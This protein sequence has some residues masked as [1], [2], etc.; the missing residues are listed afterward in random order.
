MVRR[1][2]APGKG[3]RWRPSDYPC[4]RS[5]DPAPEVGPGPA[6]T[7]RWPRASGSAWARSAPPC[8][9]AQAAG[10]DWAQVQAPDRRGPGGAA[11]RAARRRRSRGT[12]P[13]P[14]CAYLHAERR[15]PGVTLE[16]LHLEYLEQHPDGYRY[17]QFCELYRRWLR[18]R[19]LSMRQVHRAGEKLLRRLRRA[20]SRRSSTPPTGRG[21]RGRALRRRPRRL[22][23]HLR[24][25]D[26]HPAGPR[27]DRQPPAGLRLLRRRH[28]RPSSA[29]SSRAA[30]PSPA[31]TSRACSAPTRS[32]RSTTAP[33]SCP[34]AP[35]PRDKRQAS[36]C[37]SF[38]H[39]RRTLGIA[40]AIAEALPGMG[41][42]QRAGR[43]A[44]RGCGPCHR[45]A[46][47]A[48]DA[49]RT[50]SAW[51]WCDGRRVGRRSRVAVS[52]PARAE[53]L[54][55]ARDPVGLRGACGP[56]GG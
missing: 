45:R 14:D 21:H 54:G 15:K 19:G 8:W 4:D 27:L 41:A 32:S 55:Q 44:R 40:A 50:R 13:S 34:P 18:R 29:I 46:R 47:R 43:A 22:E 1:P 56:A 36:Y 11:V 10:L 24:R 33:S 39:V 52:H 5:G 12:G 9:R 6:A 17:T 20:R 23:L 48:E 31:A 7:A 38:P 25:G 2:S 26:P 30:S 53:V 37:S 51:R 49:L 42:R 35:K 28:R 3:A 16:L